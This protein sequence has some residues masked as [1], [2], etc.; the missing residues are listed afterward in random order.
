MALTQ[1]ALS[2]KNPLAKQNN[3]PK[4][5][6]TDHHLPSSLNS[7]GIIV[8]IFLAVLFLNK[9]FEMLREIYESIS[10]I[11]ESI[12]ASNE[13]QQDE[14]GYYKRN[15]SEQVPRVLVPLALTLHAI[16]RTI[17]ATLWLHRR[18]QTILQAKISTILGRMFQPLC[19][20]STRSFP[21]GL[22]AYPS[23]MLITSH[24]M[25]H[26][27]WY[28]WVTQGDHRANSSLDLLGSLKHALL[29]LESLARLSPFLPISRRPPDP[30][31]HDPT[32]NQISEH[33]TGTA[34]YIAQS[35]DI[36]FHESF[37]LCSMQY[38]ELHVVYCTFPRKQNMLHRR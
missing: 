33:T 31:Q 23:K 25:L 15:K 2:P 36:L 11:A 27:A 28:N 18:T 1:S 13:T 21:R 34:N 22:C 32:I 19:L 14:E 10:T 26:E 37:L 5:D 20:Q 9:I 38:N 35:I 7:T 8:G 24:I 12:C 3:Q 4:T 16:M 30:L 17:Q 6:E 29:D